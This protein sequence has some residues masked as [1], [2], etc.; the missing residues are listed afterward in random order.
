MKDPRREERVHRILERL[1]AVQERRDL[2]YHVE[3]LNK[4]DVNAFTL[5]GGYIYVFKGLL[6]FVE[7][8]D[9][10]AYVIAHEIGHNT[11]KHPVKKLQGALGSQFLLLASLGAN[12]ARFSRGL[13]LALVSIFTEYSQEDEFLADSLGVKYAEEAGFNPRASIEFLERLED[14]FKKKPPSQI[15]YFRTHPY[16]PQRIANIK[17]I[18]GIPLDLKD[19]LNR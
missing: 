16:I 1:T 15:S 14:Y 3:I 12:S 11:A 10:L 5:P 6:D 2:V 8:D 7:S 19:F 9:E 13:E 18:L 4:D 17:K